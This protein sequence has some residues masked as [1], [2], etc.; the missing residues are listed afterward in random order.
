M[1]FTW[2]VA[3]PRVAAP[4]VIVI[5]SPAYVPDPAACSW[6]MAKWAPA[7]AT[8]NAWTASSPPKP[9]LTSPATI[10]M[11]PSVTM[12][13]NRAAM[14]TNIIM[15]P[16]SRAAARASR[17]SE[18]LTAYPPLLV[19][20]GSQVGE[21]RVGAPRGSRGVRVEGAADVDQIGVDGSKEPG[22]PAIAPVFAAAAAYGH[23]PV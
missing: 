1:Q 6:P 4:L 8:L 16:P 12:A 17:C 19:F 21:V 22:S 15:A 20:P 11:T 2:I 14:R 9:S 3:V 18:G 13:I 5:V 7:S 23:Q 10:R